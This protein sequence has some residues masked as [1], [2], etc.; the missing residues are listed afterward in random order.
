[1]FKSSKG[2]GPAVGNKPS[3]KLSP[4]T[5]G[6]TTQ[7][8]APKPK[9]PVEVYCRL[10][11]LK[12]EEAQSCANVISESVLQLNP[13]ECSHDFKSGHKNPTQHTFKHVF[14]EDSIQTDLF[15][16]LGFPFVEDLLQGKDGL[17]FAYGIT[18]SGKTY[19]MT[20]EPDQAGV[21]PRSLDVIFNS[22]T[23]VQA[24]K[25]AFRPDGSNGY[26]IFTEAEARLEQQRTRP[27]KISPRM[28][29][30]LPEFGDLLRIPEPRTVERGVDEDSCYA[31]FVSYVEIYNNFIYDLLEEQPANTVNPKPPQ[32]K[33]MREDHDRNMYVSGVT[34]VEVKSTEEAFEVLYQGQKLRRVAQTQLNTESSRSHSVFTIRVV[35]APLDH[36]GEDIIQDKS[37]VMVS[38]LSLVDLAGSERTSRTHSQGERLREA[39]N[40]NNSLMVL[41]NCMEALRDNQSKNNT[42]LVPYRDSK[43]TLLFK[44]T[45]DGEGKVRMVVCVSPHAEDYDESI[46]VM[47][48]AEVT[49]EVVVDRPQM[50]RV[51][52]GLAPGRRRANLLY[53]AALQEVVSS[54]DGEGESL[55]FHPV[56]PHPFS[57]ALGVIA[58]QKYLSE[59]GEA[60]KLAELQSL[61]EHR[62]TTRTQLIED[63]KKKQVSF[64]EQLVAQETEL[65]QLRATVKELKQ[66]KASREKTSK[67]VASLKS[68][69]S[70]QDEQIAQLNSELER[71][72]LTGSTRDRELGKVKGELAAIARQK[73]FLARTT[74]MY[75]AD[76]R[77]LEM[78][79]QS[80][81]KEVQQTQADKENYKKKLKGFVTHEREK[82][83]RLATQM[84]HREKDL[85]V[86]NAKLRQVTDLIRNSPC[87]SSS[88][89]APRTPLK[90]TTTT[91]N[92]GGSRTPGPGRVGVREVVEGG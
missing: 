32:S 73:D 1:M 51:D 64:R 29:T 83:E 61:L 58:V 30:E 26:N 23:D 36:N 44:N 42:R 81:R 89:A 52:S 12:E 7:Q 21:L 9:D 17:L 41:R 55:G 60:F 67:E 63:L 59:E 31:V 34:E 46:H 91:T 53:K 5:P 65:S 77:E 92:A 43:L 38:Q 70:S 18:N 69:V 87:A 74:E 19:T 20:G 27:K 86:K 14:D 68:L 40:I 13:P 57:L 10:R 6:K 33:I 45:F 76:K 79:L 78:E 66:A 90:S 72:R 50:V 80:E 56:A 2:K 49:Q 24:S 37:R 15:D 75:E 4:T 82:Y 35:M 48:F 85:A 84:K 88:A 22:I 47:K 3:K 16:S 71:G 28:R 8:K 39:G 54:E 11:P 62:H 25:Y